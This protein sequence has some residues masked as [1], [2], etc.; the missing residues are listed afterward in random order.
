LDSPNDLGV[1]SLAGTRTATMLLHSAANR[2]NGE[3][4]PDGRWVAYSARGL[5][6]GIVAVVPLADDPI[7]TNRAPFHSLE[8][9]MRLLKGF[10]VATILITAAPVGAETGGRLNVIEFADWAAGLKQLCKKFEADSV[11]RSPFSGPE[12]VRGVGGSAS[13]LPT[14]VSLGSPKSTI[15][16]GFHCNCLRESTGTRL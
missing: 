1:I 2:L 3:I 9:G 13:S 5:G 12:I 8:V 11:P 16:I 15:R 14:M 7:R 10:L 6:F 4:S